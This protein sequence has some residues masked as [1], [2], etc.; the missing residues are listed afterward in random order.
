MNWSSKKPTIPG[1][2]WYR[3]KRGEPKC[4]EFVMIK[5]LGILFN[6]LRLPRDLDSWPGE[7]A[8]PIPM[9]SESLVRKSKKLEQQ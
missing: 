1:W 2:Y 7:Y 5:H 8:G 4:V 3:N 6:D 9:P